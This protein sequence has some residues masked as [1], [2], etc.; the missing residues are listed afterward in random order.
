MF[1]EFVGQTVVIDLRSQFVCLG[2]LERYDEHSVWLRDADMHD[3]RDSDTSRENYIA[4][5]LMTGIKRNR[6][7]V[8]LARSEVVAVSKLSDV[9]DE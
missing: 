4:A 3:L 9:V 8:A 6:Q 1:A 2:K 7:L 5:S